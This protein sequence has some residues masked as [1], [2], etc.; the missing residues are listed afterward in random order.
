[1]LPKDMNIFNDD[2]AEFKE[3]GKVVNSQYRIIRGDGT[4][5]WVQL[6][7]STIKCAEKTIPMCYF[8]DITKEMDM[9]Q[10][11]QVVA[12][13]IGDSIS[14]FKIKDNKE[15]LMY[16]NDVFMK[17]WALQKVIMTRT[18]RK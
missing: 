2:H 5:R 7:I 16:A 6:N 1:M 4:I 10:N 13:N 18:K 3:T 12:N 9:A 17:Q 11:L 15:T 8:I 14:I